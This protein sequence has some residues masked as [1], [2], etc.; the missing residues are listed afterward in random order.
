MYLPYVQ[1]LE[2]CLGNR[3]MARLHKSLVIRT[4]SS[5]A[6]LT[7]AVRHAVAEVDKDQAVYAFK[8][9]EQV[10]ASSASPYRFY[11]LLLGLFASVALVLATIGTYG[12]ISYSVSERTHEIGIRLALGAQ[13]R[14][15]LALIVRHGL[16][17]SLIGVV[18]GLI[19]SFAATRILSNFL[20]AVTA[21]DPITFVVVSL[22]LVSIT[23]LATYIPARR[24]T[25]VD[26]MVALRCE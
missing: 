25:K 6:G 15:V 26:P 10:L 18:L 12:V 23:L 16:V 20:F 8:S 5:S 4:A 3:K 1:Q 2:I 9:M 17:F 22:V 21:H 19:A 24:A 7:T 14:E 13:P 11:M